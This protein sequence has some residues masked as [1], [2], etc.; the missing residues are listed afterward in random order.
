MI[1][2]KGAISFQD[3]YLIPLDEATYYLEEAEKFHKQTKGM[4]L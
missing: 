3:A 1:V 2:Y 4:S